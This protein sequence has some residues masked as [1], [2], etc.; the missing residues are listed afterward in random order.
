M[1]LDNC[2][3]QTEEPLTEDGGEGQCGHSQP[4]V[5]AQSL[6]S[7]LETLRRCYVFYFP[8]PDR[9]LAPLSDSQM[10]VLKYTKQ[11]ACIFSIFHPSTI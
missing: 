1:L 10:F 7:G 11:Q 9:K 2:V 5:H 6:S 3:I 4:Q 8:K